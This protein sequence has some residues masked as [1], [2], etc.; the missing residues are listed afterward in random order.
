MTVS[1]R[2][3]RAQSRVGERALPLW[4][5][6]LVEPGV[7][8]GA[9]ELHGIRLYRRRS[10][11]GVFLARARLQELGKGST[12][13]QQR[14]D[15]TPL[16]SDLLAPKLLFLWDIGGRSEV[17]GG[18]HN[19]PPKGRRGFEPHPAHQVI[20]TRITRK[21]VGFTPIKDRPSWPVFYFLVDSATI[22]RRSAP[23]TRH[24]TP[25]EFISPFSS[26]FRCVLNQR[27]YP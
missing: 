2:A 4:G 1:D 3:L 5:Y 17:T 19:P 20:R 7:G 8:F 22:R 21:S 27:A 15:L 16:S 24:A 23:F 25:P 12:K 26:R 14:C 6:F 9:A 18:T 10:C 11:S 13:V